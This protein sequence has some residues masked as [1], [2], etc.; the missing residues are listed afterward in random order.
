MPV[1]AAFGCERPADP[2]DLGVFQ[3]SDEIIRRAE[4][5]AAEIARVGDVGE[6]QL[7]TLPR[8][9]HVVTEPGVDDPAIIRQA[10]IGFPTNL[11]ERVAETED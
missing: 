6:R 2:I 4:F 1:D 7:S 10:C 9:P 5:A 8:G 3:L 11:Y